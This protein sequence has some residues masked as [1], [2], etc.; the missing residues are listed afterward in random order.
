[1]LTFGPIASTIQLRE[2]VSQIK[3]VCAHTTCGVE[4]PVV[5]VVYVGVWASRRA[6]SLR[7]AIAPET[8]RQMPTLTPRRRRGH[9][10]GDIALCSQSEAEVAL[11]GGYQRCGY[12]IQIPHITLR[13]SSNIKHHKHMNVDRQLTSLW[14]MT[15]SLLWP[16]WPGGRVS[17]MGGEYC[18]F[19]CH[20][21]INK[22]LITHVCSTSL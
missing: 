8:R 12:H 17:H 3:V 1:M 22:L 19:L 4:S 11:T 2:D 5:H 16:L 6:E 20:K 7:G 21:V 13:D 9:A 14:L 18:I 15:T 10:H